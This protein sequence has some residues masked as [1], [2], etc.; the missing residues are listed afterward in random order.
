MPFLVSLL[1]TLTLEG[2]F[3]QW[4]EDIQSQPVHQEVHRQ[5]Q[6]C[7]GCFPLQ[8]PWSNPQKP[9]NAKH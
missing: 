5:W 7:H 2:S 8:H 3:H 9:V 4:F 1:Y 6:S